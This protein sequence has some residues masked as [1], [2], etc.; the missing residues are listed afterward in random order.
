AL[1]TVLLCFPT[2]AAQAEAD[3]AA[4]AKQSLEQ[5]IRP[6]YAHL[7][8]T[9]DA[10]N[11]AV[12]ALCQK[13]SAALKEAKEAFAATAEAWSLV[14]PIRF[15]PVAEQH[16]YER[17]FYWPDP[18]GLGARQVREALG[19]EDQAV[20]EAASL[21]GKS[22]ALQGLPALEYL[23][24][25]DDAGTLAKGGSDA[26]FRCRFAETIAGYVAGM[27]RDIASGWQ[28]GAAYTKAYLEPGPANSA[29]HT[30]KEVTLELFKT[31]TTGIEMVRDHK[32]AKALGAKPEQ[33]RPQL[34]PFWRS[35][36]SFANMAGNLEGVRELFAKG[37]FAQVV[38]ED[39]AGVE[40]SIVFDLNHAVQVLRGI[41]KPIAEAV[42]DED[43]RAKLEAL[44]VG[45]KSAVTTA[46]DAISRG[47][48][49]TFGFNAMDG[50]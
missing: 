28:D 18:K 27:A 25:G 10:L 15:G 8:E 23:L 11:Q 43:I 9:T 48:G 26:M 46:G 35:G 42:H 22:V 5:F 40:D 3:H 38:H 12:A 16:R 14:E 31:F 13:P 20:T 50:D 39:S 44:R 21:S 24:Y 7:A 37:G 29:Y 47:A 45:L 4:I 36:L 6:G 33:A 17:I 19:K 30:P 41:D 2:G 1:A 49:L 32:M 34:V